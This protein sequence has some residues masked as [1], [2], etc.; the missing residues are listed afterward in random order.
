MGAFS[1]TLATEMSATTVYSEKVLV[2]M[3]WNSCLPLQ[4][5]LDVWSGIR[6]WPWVTLE[7][8][9]VK[10]QADTGKYII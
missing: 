9:N 8:E 2:P 7:N 4:V 1:S 10:G 5:N 3:K 6:P